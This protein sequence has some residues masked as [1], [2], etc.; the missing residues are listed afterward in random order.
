MLHGNTCSKKNIIQKFLLHWKDE[1]NQ[2]PQGDNN[3]NIITKASI[4]KK[5]KELS[6]WQ[7]YPEEGFFFGKY[8]WFVKKEFREMYGLKDLPL[9]NKWDSSITLL[10]GNP[11]SA[12]ITKF[13]KIL[14]EEERKK[15]LEMKINM[16]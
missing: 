3:A 16:R 5:I 13:T 8:C 9:P 12:K 4:S 7:E 11:D 6:S 14:T 15:Q 2:V 1:E 10:D